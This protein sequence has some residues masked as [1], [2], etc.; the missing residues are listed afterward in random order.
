MNIE[1]NYIRHLYCIERIIDG[2][3]I[4]AIAELGYDSL[5]RIIFR[6]KDINTAEKNSEE[7][8]KRFQLARDAK[9]YVENVME[10]H[11]VRVYSE[12]FKKGGFGRYLG[13]MYYEKDGQWIDLNKEMLDKG[14]AQAYYKGASKDY[15][16]W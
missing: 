16:E 9:A 8:T 5:N 2:D 11:K 12:K 4:V 14:L 13:I 10:N 6:F 15:G 1:D 7:G 3:T